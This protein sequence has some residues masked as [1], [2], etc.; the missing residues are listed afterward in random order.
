MLVQE[1]CEH[2]VGWF[3]GGLWV[4]C[5]NKVSK[6]QNRNR[7]RCYVNITFTLDMFYA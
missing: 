5:V 6:S 1:I 2:M 4:V 3:V 7:V